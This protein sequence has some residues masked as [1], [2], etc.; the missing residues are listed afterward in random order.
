MNL[1][2]LLFIMLV[3]ALV[4]AVKAF[5]QDDLSSYPSTNAEGGV[6]RQHHSRFAAPRLQ[7]L[8]RT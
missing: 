5:G 6:Q 4:G 2:A 7:A 3:V 1:R 8:A